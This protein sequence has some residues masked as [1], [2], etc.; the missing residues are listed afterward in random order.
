MLLK[1]T[2][3][4]CGNTIKKL[5]YKGQLVAPFLACMECGGVLEKD[6]S[7]ISMSSFEQ[8]E[9]GTRK[10]ELRRDYAAKNQERRDKHLQLLSDRERILKREDNE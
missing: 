2:C 1:Y 9:S 4:R 7:D 3:K 10:V 5:Y 6:L 8:V